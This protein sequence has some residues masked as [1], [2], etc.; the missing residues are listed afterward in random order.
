MTEVVV[1]VARFWYRRLRSNPKAKPAR[2]LQNSN[3][4]VQNGSAAA[5]TFC[6][7]GMPLL[8]TCGRDLNYCDSPVDLI[9]G[10]DLRELHRDSAVHVVLR[11]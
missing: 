2:I 10:L 1:I 9:P 5:P 3:S 8:T 6:D 4:L 7:V 11:L